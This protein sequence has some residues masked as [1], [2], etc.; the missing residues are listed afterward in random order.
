MNQTAASTAVNAKKLEAIAA[1]ISAVK[2]T[3]YTQVGAVVV[4]RYKTGW[5][6][7]RNK[8]AT[9][10]YDSSVNR[11]P[12]IPIGR[13]S[14]VIH[15]LLWA[16]GKMDTNSP[17]VFKGASYTGLIGLIGFLVMGITSIPLFR[18]RFYEAFKFFH[19]VGLV[20]LKL[21]LEF[22]ARVRSYNM[23]LSYYFTSVKSAVFTSLPGGLTQIEVDRL[24]DGWK[25]GLLYNFPLLHLYIYEGQHVYIRVFNGRRTLEK[26]PFT[27][28]N[29]P[30]R[31]APSGRNTLVLVVKAAGAFTGSL[32]RV[33]YA[34]AA[35]VGG[36]YEKSGSVLEGDILSA[37]NG[38]AS[39]S[40]LG[41]A[42]EG[43]LIIFV[44]TP[45]SP[46]GSSLIDM[47]DFETVLLFAGGSGFTY[48]MSTLEHIVGSAS[49][50]QG[51]TKTVFVV[52]TLR[53]LE[54]VQVF[55]NAL[56]ST[57]S[58]GQEH[59][60]QIIMR[61]HVTSEVFH[62]DLNPVPY[63]QIIS[64][65]SEPSRI[66]SEALETTIISIEQRGETTGCG[67]GVGACGPKGLVDAAR[68]AVTSSDTSQASKAGGIKFYSLVF[69]HFF[70]SK[71]QMKQRKK[72][73]DEHKI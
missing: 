48:C 11:A 10:G 4:S 30:A 64:G 7:K 73:K 53:D 19:I 38:A 51:V 45:S 71:K 52:W 33:G 39:E 29:A 46:Y 36:D 35:L 2:I 72:L 24:S 15:G 42:I 9:G 58:R 34:E 8:M 70:F 13:S 56:N 66:L 12:N 57:I 31:L 65:R 50:G 47:C 5:I 69:H 22:Y 26:H 23:I 43:M 21:S 41:V 54:M 61:I 14:T 3:L 59:Q 20:N 18:S 49:Y 27:I 37:Y 68:A 25:A 16:K 55:A 60:M 62:S 32:H 17:I 40:R 44:K 1:T 6:L 28:A 67:V 63:A